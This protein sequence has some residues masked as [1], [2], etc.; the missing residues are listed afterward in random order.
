[1]SIYRIPARANAGIA[2]AGVELSEAMPL[3]VCAI[4]GLFGSKIFGGSFFVVVLI[5]GFLASK[6]LVKFKKGRLDGFLTAYLYVHGLDGYSIAFNSAKKRFIGDGQGIN[7]GSSVFVDEC[8][9][10]INKH[11]NKQTGSSKNGTK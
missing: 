3:V 8:I 4:I 6:E 11:G 7:T 9:E 2:F 1:M 10:L 5:G